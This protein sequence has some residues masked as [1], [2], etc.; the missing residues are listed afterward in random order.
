MTTIATREKERR[1]RELADLAAQV[2]GGSDYAVSAELKQRFPGHWTVRG[3]SPEAIR[4][5]LRQI[6]WMK[7]GERTGGDR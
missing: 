1:F 3:R 5:D 7:R 6:R 2:S 4:G